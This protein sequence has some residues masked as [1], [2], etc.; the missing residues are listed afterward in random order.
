MAM[1]SYVTKHRQ[2]FTSPSSLSDLSGERAS[3]LSLALPTSH[4]GRVCSTS[5]QLWSFHLSLF[6]SFHLLSS[7]T[8]SLLTC[9]SIRAP[10]VCLNCLFLFCSWFK[11]KFQIKVWLNSSSFLW[12][13]L[14]SIWGRLIAKLC[15]FSLSLCLSA[16]SD[17][18]SDTETAKEVSLPA[19]RNTSRGERVMNELLTAPVFR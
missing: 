17:T 1:A 15:H 12:L 14:L 2:F 19:E 6:P 16:G 7:Q 4:S 10:D 3:S 18:D 9:T 11:K 5:L 13:P 8:L